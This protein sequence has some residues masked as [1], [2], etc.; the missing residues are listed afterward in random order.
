[1]DLGG[2]RL[3]DGDPSSLDFACRVDG[4]VADSPVSGVV[5]SAREEDLILIDVTEQARG[6]GR[7][8]HGDP[9]RHHR[10]R[11]REPDRP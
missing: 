5:G 1:M 8:M 10:R 7:T 3:V 9:R 4:W 11:A 2:Y 6:V